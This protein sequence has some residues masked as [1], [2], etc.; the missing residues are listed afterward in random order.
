[1]YQRLNNVHA[2]G[3][4]QHPQDA[5]QSGTRRTATPRKPAPALRAICAETPVPTP[6]G[7]VPAG[8]L[9]IGDHV[10][11]TDGP[12]VRITRITRRVFSHNDLVLNRNLAPIRIEVDPFTGL[13]NGTTLLVSPDLPLHPMQ[14]SPET[15]PAR[16]LYDGCMIRSVCPEDGIV[17]IE[18]ELDR[19]ATLTLDGL[20]IRLSPETASETDTGDALIAQ[21]SLGWHCEETRVFRPIR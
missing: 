7:P 14:G 21:S 10:T 5:P 3:P 2:F 6:A 15:L 1:M 20:P 13:S 18:I 16:A 17:Y 12:P 8:A 9:A 19:P 11:A 4:F